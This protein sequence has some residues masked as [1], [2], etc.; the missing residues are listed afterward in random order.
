M[1]LC[2][3][4]DKLGA[5]LLICI[6]PLIVSLLTEYDSFYPSHRAH[7][8]GNCEEGKGVQ[9]G[10]VRTT[11]VLVGA[12]LRSLNSASSAGAKLLGGRAADSSEPGPVC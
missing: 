4:S 3:K 11:M 12:K 7:T 10:A 6:K 8:H 5:C 2:F 1:P 9:G